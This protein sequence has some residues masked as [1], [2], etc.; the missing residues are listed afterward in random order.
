MSSP[1]RLPR[2]VWIAFSRRHQ[3]GRSRAR[4][5]RLPASA[6]SLRML[7]RIVLPKLKSASTK[8][9]QS[10]LR[11]NNT[12]P[13]LCRLSTPVLKIHPNIHLPGLPWFA[14]HRLSKKRMSQRKTRLIR[15]SQRSPV[16]PSNSP[17]PSTL[18]Q[19]LFQP[20][21]RHRLPRQGFLESPHPSQTVMLRNPKALVVQHASRR[22]FLWRQRTTSFMSHPHAPYPLPN[23]P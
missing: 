23:R 8:L 18:Q 5:L 11:R 9:D 10:L 15:S 3:R 16:R 7:N 20:S 21:N 17:P 22:F 12:Q 4:P 19:A 1:R 13:D 14:C 6:C 2:E